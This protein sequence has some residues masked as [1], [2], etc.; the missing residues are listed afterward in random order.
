MVPLC[1]EYWLCCGDDSAEPITSL[2]CCWLLPEG[3]RCTPE[4]KVPKVGTVPSLHV[5]FFCCSLLFFLLISPITIR[6]GHKSDLAYNL[7]FLPPQ[8]LC[9]LCVL[10]L[11]QAVALTMALI[12][13]KKVSLPH[14][15]CT[16]LQTQPGNDEH[17]SPLSDVRLVSEQYTRRDQTLLR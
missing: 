9:V 3:A 13:E 11:L 16:F 5:G 14:L 8:F 10:L 6:A 2:Q 4:E 7:S 15:S 17:L 1:F 12:F